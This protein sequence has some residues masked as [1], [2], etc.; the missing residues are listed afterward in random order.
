MMLT[1]GNVL[2]KNGAQA[3]NENLTDILANFLF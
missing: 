3:A 2:N 1:S